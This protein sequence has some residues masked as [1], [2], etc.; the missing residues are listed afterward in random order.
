[1]T[2]RRK[3]ERWPDVHELPAVAALARGPRLD[4][5]ACIGRAPLFD[6][7]VHGES[8]D[9]RAARHAAARR[10]CTTCPARNDCA[11]IARHIPPAHRQGIYAARLYGPRAAPEEQQSA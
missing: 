11:R 9:V 10:I 4:G 3:I 6:V 5:A 1:M 8:P 7:D 2:G